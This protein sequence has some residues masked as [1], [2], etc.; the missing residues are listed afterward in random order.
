M[1]HCKASFYMEFFDNDYLGGR[2][3]KYDTNH[4]HMF[5]DGPVTLPVVEMDDKDFGT[6]LHE[7]IHYL[8]HITTM[9]GVRIGTMF[10]HMYAIYRDYLV[11]HKNETITLPLELWKQDKKIGNFIEHFNKVKGSSKCDYNVDAV[12][13][14]PQDI[15]NANNNKTAVPVGIY[16]FENEKVVENAFQFGYMCIIES[17]ADMV[18]S[19]IYPNAAHLSVPYKTVQMICQSIHPDI[20]SDKKKMIALCLCAL[21]CDNPG[22]RFFEILNT[23]NENKN[24]K[25]TG[26]ELYSDF[27]ANM[28]I[29]KCQ[30]IRLSTL[31]DQFLDD[32]KDSLSNMLGLK[33]NYYSIVINS[34]KKETSNMTSIL[35]QILYSKNDKEELNKN[36]FKDLLDYFG[37][38]FID[39]NEFE[40]MPMDVKNNRPYPETAAL[41]GWELI[42]DRLT[43]V[44]GIKDCMRAALCRKTCSEG[45][46]N[47]F[48]IECTMGYQWTKKEICLFTKALKYFGL[49]GIKF[50]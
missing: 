9:Y 50:E 3:S 39:S 30:N 45:N 21:Q 31:L 44:R 22:A 23:F 15:K 48:T 1:E 35:L 10:N 17:M 38:P 25:K 33:V 40:I 43:E 18:Q 5:V 36:D 2:K 8:Q 19:F 12:E 37:Y 6:F 29:F 46:K 41:A 27:L 34:C 4:I 14:Y 47:Q 11:N 49:D 20:A 16:D 13:I 7:Y 28:V 42:F 24:L 26:L 32:Y